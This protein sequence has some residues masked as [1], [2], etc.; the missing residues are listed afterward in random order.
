MRVAVLGATSQI[1]KDLIRSMGESG[2]YQLFLFARRP[3]ALREFLKGRAVAAVAYAGDYASFST[4]QEFDALIN[5][6]GVGN[7]A[8]AAQ[9]G[10]D[11]LDVTFQFDQ[12]ALNYL[13]AHPQCRYI[14]LSSGAA[15]GSNFERPVDADSSASIAI[16]HLKPQ[17]WYGVAKLHAEC[18]HRAL[19]QLPIVDVRVFNYFSYTQDL[20]ARF[21]ITDVLRAI[22]S[23]ETLETSSDNII[24]DYIG[25]GDFF[26][27]ISKILASPIVNDVLDCYTREPVDKITLLES[28]K[29]RFGLRY[30]FSPASVGI[31]A[32]GLKMNY[33]SKSRR[34]EAFGYAPA[35]NS[36]Q[37][38]LGEAA[39]VLPGHGPL[40]R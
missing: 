40:K 35:K 7:P 20:S 9:M 34:A 4:D 11:I 38:V 12:L 39:R 16:N 1:A 18:R 30:E 6:V 26:Q 23:G 21:F 3:E 36:L 28:M 5:F 29:E 27:L 24:R 10:A 22:E 13:R 25:P 37:T 14:F 17:D 8:A 32:T 33:F 31:N 15:Y 19:P 2:R